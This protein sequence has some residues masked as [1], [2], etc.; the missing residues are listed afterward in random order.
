MPF[1]PVGG[2]FLDGVQFSTDP[3]PY[4]PMNWEKRYSVH[5]GIGGKSTI[6]DFGTFMSD[7]TLR[8]GSGGSR[9]LE[10]AAVIALHT[11]YRVRGASYVFTDWLV[12]NFIVFITAFAPVPWKRGA[13]EVGGTVSFYTY[14]MELQV[15]QI[16]ALLGVTYTG[17]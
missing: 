16:N 17:P 12:N 10:E 4:E 7:N 8:L 1:L 6:Q 11:R 9:F 3:E 13:D 14:T 5:K 2:V 15:I